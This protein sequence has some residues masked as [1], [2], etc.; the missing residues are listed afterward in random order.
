M[1][2]KEKSTIMGLLRQGVIGEEVGDELLEGVDLKLE[3][4]ERGETTVRSEEAEEVRGV[5]ADG[6]CRVESRSSS[7]NRRLI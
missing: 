2:Q 4:V 1:L 3:Q 7:R 6:S 5:L